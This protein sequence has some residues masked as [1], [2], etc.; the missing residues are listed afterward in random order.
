MFE[1]GRAVAFFPCVASIS[2]SPTIKHSPQRGGFQF[3]FSL[4]IPS[5]LSEIHGILRNEI[6]FKLQGDKQGQ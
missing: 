3:I 5:P 4:N 2:L 1:L 6:Y